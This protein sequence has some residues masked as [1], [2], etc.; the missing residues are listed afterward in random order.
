MKK[1]LM[2][3]NLTLSLMS[4][5]ALA[6]TSSSLNILP[7][8]LDLVCVHV[9]ESNSTIYR[10]TVQAEQMV[11]VPEN[12][13]RFSQLTRQYK[14]IVETL[15]LEN[16]TSEILSTVNNE[17]TL[18]PTEEQN[19][20]FISMK[21]NLELTCHINRMNHGGGGFSGSN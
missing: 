14:A 5:G 4:Y 11:G 7:N 8:N 3:L 16:N 21:L 13:P 1:I 15:N 10:I 12:Q 2:G 6:K 18:S 19:Y 9:E 17:F 20:K